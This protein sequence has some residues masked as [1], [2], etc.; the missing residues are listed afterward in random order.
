M[1]RKLTR[2]QYHQTIRFPLSTENEI[3]T[4]IS[5]RKLDNL[6][7]KKNKNQSVFPLFVDCLKNI[8]RFDAWNIFFFNRNF[9]KIYI[10]RKSDGR[11]KKNIFFHFI[12]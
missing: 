8:V 4:K 6:K 3:P 2:R 5:I 9:L 12:C 10:F 7:K 11:K 1:G